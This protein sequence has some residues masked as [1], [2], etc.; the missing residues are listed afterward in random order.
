MKN[1]LLIFSTALLFSLS[2][3]AKSESN[4]K[5]LKA[6][7]PHSKEIFDCKS[8]ANT[9]AL[10]N[11]GRLFV[12]LEVNDQAEVHRIKINDEKTSLQDLNI[13]KCVVD[14]L[15]TVKFPKANKGKLAKFS[16]EVFFK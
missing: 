2:S 8:Q 1:N 9:S 14:V 3:F 16:Y 13:Q 15:K 10:I 5:F 6:I 4:A 12:D 11:A 7:K